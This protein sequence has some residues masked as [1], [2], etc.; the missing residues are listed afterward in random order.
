VIESERAFLRILWWLFNHPN[1]R[2]RT[3][4][5]NLEFS[6]WLRQYCRPSV[7]AGLCKL[8]GVDLG[9]FVAFDLDFILYDYSR[10]LVQLL[11]VKTHNAKPSYSQRKTFETLDRMLALGAPL[12]NVTY[13]GL[14]YLEMDGEQPFESELFKWNDE[15]ISREECWRRINMLDE[16]T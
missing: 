1:K 11:E 9:C 12:A 4:E 7:K 13:L 16:L 5:R 3:G 10:N 14:N 2:E 15:D 8:D 6:T